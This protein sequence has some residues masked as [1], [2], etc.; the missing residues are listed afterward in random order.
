M[1][2]IDLYVRIR[3][4]SMK[5]GATLFVAS[6][7]SFMLMEARMLIGLPESPWDTIS[8]IVVAIVIILV[9]LLYINGSISETLGSMLLPVCLLWCGLTACAAA[10]E[11]VPGNLDLWIVAFFFLMCACVFS[12]VRIVTTR[13]ETNGRHARRVDE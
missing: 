12:L 7:I 11:F 4:N 1:S 5:F 2:M 9:Y 6:L 10:D 13:L 3:L 8:I